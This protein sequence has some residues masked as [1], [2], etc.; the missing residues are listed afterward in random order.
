MTASLL[1]S[2]TLVGA[3]MAAGCASPYAVVSG[4]YVASADSI[5][6]NL[7][8]GWRQYNAALDHQ[9]LARAVVARV[10]E[11]REFIRDSLRIT[12][13]GFSLQQIAIGRIRVGD[14]LPHTRKKIASGMSPQEAADVMADNVRSNQKLLRPLIQSN[15]P[16]TV[17]GKPG[18]KL[19]YSYETQEGL[20]INV[21]YYGSLSDPALYYLMFEAPAQYYFSRD[22]PVFEK[23]RQSF[24]ILSGG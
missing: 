22:L 17:G 4:A 12:K 23:V 20:R 19:L 16:A 14:D 5:S 9:P 7:P 1:A 18:F 10:E 6:V 15:E 3:S 13:D 21:A 11:R 24:K 8:S 2:A